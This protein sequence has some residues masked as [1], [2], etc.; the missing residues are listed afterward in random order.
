LMRRFNNLL[1][2]ADNLGE[3]EKRELQSLQRSLAGSASETASAGG[4]RRV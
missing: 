2:R 4:G 3:A 1:G